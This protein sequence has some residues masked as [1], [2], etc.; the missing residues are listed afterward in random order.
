MEEEGI[1]YSFE[2]AA[3]SHKMIVADAPQ[4]HVEPGKTHV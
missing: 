1:Y 3:G 4:S 2:H